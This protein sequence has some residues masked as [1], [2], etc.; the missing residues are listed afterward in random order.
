V[1]FEITAQSYASHSPDVVILTI[2]RDSRCESRAINFSVRF[3]SLGGRI[4][5]RMRRI[6]V[7]EFQHEPVF[8]EEFNRVRCPNRSVP[9]SKVAG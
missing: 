1:S 8:T 6:A 2:L 4:L 3:A 7:L 5:I 9:A